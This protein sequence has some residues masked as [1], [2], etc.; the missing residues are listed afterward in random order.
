VTCREFAAFIADYLAG[1]LPG[2]TRGVFERHVALCANC[3]T[4][5]SSYRSAIEAGRR[6]FAADASALPADVPPE[7]IAA[8]VSALRARQG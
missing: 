5:L 6:A 4:Y 8:I 1:E 3:R 2:E 7:L